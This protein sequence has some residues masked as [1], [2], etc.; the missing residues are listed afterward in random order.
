MSQPGS[1]TNRLRSGA[2][3]QDMGVDFNAS[4]SA[5]IPT[6][7]GMSQESFYVGAGTLRV[8]TING[9]VVNFASGE[10]AAGVQHPIRISR[11]HSTGTT[12]TAVKLIYN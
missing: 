9:T 10:L 11:V 5:D 4:D 12:A 1:N 8:T 7:D 3:V 2:E 6:V